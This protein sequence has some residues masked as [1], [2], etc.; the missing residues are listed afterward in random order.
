MDGVDAP[1]LGDDAVAQPAHRRQRLVDLDAGG[2]DRLGRRGEHRIEPPEILHELERTGQLLAGRLGRVVEQRRRLGEPGREPLGVLQAPELAAQ[3]VFLPHAQA[4]G[5]ELAHLEPHQ[6]LALRAVPGGG[7]CP[8]GFLARRAML[9]VQRGDPRGGLLGVGE[10]VEQLQL[11]DR[12]QQPLVLVLAVDLDQRVAEPFEEADG[13]R[14]VVHERAVA[15]GAGQLAPDDD[16][17]VVVGDEP[18]VVENGARAVGASER[19]ERLD[20]RRLGVGA[21]HV[22]LRA[23]AAHEHDRVD[24]DRLAGPGLAGEDVEAGGEGDGDGLDD[25]EVSEAQLA[26]HRPDA[27]SRAG[28]AQEVSGRRRLSAPPT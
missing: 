22:G 8:L 16:L 21:D 28:E 19:E 26:E 13:H 18:G 2:V 6:V 11:A 10:A 25:G 7:P 1:R 4:R 14:R 20:R 15:A 27:R 12:L 3:L 17:A 5:V 23:T 9:R 24:Q